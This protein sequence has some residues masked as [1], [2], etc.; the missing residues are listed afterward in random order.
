MRLPPVNKPP[1]HA[2]RSLPAGTS[3][4]SRPASQ[5][6]HPTPTTAT[7][8]MHTTL[9]LSEVHGVVFGDGA[10]DIGGLAP[11]KT[12]GG[13][14]SAPLPFFF[15]GGGGPYPKLLAGLDKGQAHDLSS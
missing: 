8:R 11:N 4:G 9:R 7:G 2:G 15:F 14:G 1:S 6:T 13:G 12:W 5:P 10:I 3:P